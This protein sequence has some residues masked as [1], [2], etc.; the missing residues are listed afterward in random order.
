MSHL[1]PIA[2]LE[3]LEEVFDD[4]VPTQRRPKGVG[5]ERSTLTP[6]PMR[7]KDGEDRHVDMK[8]L[9]SEPPQLPE[10]SIDPWPLFPL[11]PK[12]PHVD[13]PGLSP[14]PVVVHQSDEWS[15][16]LTPP[17]LSTDL[18]S[19]APLALSSP[20]PAAPS[21]MPA[22]TG[23]KVATVGLAA[24]LAVGLIAVFVPIDKIANSPSQSLAATGV[25]EEPP[26][27]SV[28][29]LPVVGF[30]EEKTPEPVTV[31]EVAIFAYIPTRGEPSD[32]EKARREEADEPSAS[33]D[34]VTDDNPYRGEASANRTEGGESKTEP[35]ELAPPETL[36]PFDRGAAAA[37]LNAAAS[38]AASCR[39]PGTPA[40][41]VRVSV[42]I[43][44]SGR[45][46]TAMV[47]GAFAGT[48]VGGCI[49]KT[50]RAVRVEPFEGNLV[51]VH[52]T[53]TIR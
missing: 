13:V 15:S 45:A 52:K 22:N 33:A 1:K 12:T 17:P 23:W 21:E 37:A 47:A 38:S 3:G 46:T 35:G 28:N 5:D 6:P 51:T 32:S 16:D 7:V 18:G 41:T 43:A 29:E 48:P 14:A 30:V 49:A 10:D 4:I 19:V 24:T 44:P 25:I 34:I 36:P 50:F 20:P 31:N 39:Q 42:S 9:M 2:E 40:G 27:I 11:P 26:L 53:I 8:A